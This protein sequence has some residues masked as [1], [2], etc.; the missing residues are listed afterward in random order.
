MRCLKLG[1]A[2]T[3]LIC[4]LS[5][6]AQAADC[7]RVAASGDNITHDWAVLFTTNALKNTIAGRGLIGMGPVK[8]S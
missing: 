6:M 2:A 8:T 5:A 4:A 1:L 7:T 3:A